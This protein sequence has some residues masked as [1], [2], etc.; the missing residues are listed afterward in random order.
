MGSRAD[1]FKGQIDADIRFLEV[2][3][4]TA[5]QSKRPRNHNGLSHEDQYQDNARCQ[6]GKKGDEDIFWHRDISYA[7]PLASVMEKRK[8]NQTLKGLPI[9]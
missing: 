6:G 5:R 4:P 3:V 7:I 9:P 2:G 1:V 8:R